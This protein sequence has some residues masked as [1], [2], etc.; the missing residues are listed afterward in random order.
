[1]LASLTGHEIYEFFLEYRYKDLRNGDKEVVFVIDQMNALQESNGD[2]VNDKSAKANL[3]SW[4]QQCSVGHR[5]IL[6]SSVNYKTF[7]K[8]RHTQ[9]TE[10][11]MDVYGGFTPVSFNNIAEEGFLTVNQTEMKRDGS[12]SYTDI[13]AKYR[14]TRSGTVLI[15]PAYRSRYITIESVN[16][17]IWDRLQHAREC[18][19]H[20]LSD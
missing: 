18:R 9:T 13:E 7:L 20:M 1:M 14:S 17:N 6:S 12:S 3:L 8:R 19:D 16:R 2:N 11:T 15:H 5:A 4:L 10:A